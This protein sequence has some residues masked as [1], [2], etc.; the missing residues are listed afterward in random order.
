[1]T[2]LLPDQDRTNFMI[3]AGFPLGA[4][5]SLDAAYMYVN[6]QGRRGR[7]VDRTSDSQTA[8]ELNS[9]WYQLTANILSISLKANY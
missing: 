8:A 4:T 3:G 7:V 5:W 2:P 1:M 9:G 6:T